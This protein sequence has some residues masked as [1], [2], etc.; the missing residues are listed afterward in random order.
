MSAEDLAAAEAGEK[1]DVCSSDGH[2]TAN[3]SGTDTAETSAN[4]DDGTAAGGT[5]TATKDGATAPTVAEKFE[6]V[7]SQPT[8]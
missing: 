2:G 7:K 5:D 8:K 3:G 4:G 1:M 6:E